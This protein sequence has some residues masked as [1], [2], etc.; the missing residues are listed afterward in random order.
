MEQTSCGYE[1]CPNTIE[2]VP[3]HRHKEYCSAACRQAARRLRKAKEQQQQNASLSY[4]MDKIQSPRLHGI[5][6]QILA[7]EGE[8]ALLNLIVAID[9]ERGC[10]QASDEVQQQLAH[11]EIK[12]SHYREI[13]DLDD[14][15]KIC[16]QFLA[17]GQLVDYRALPRFSI[18]QGVDAWRDY[19]SWTHEATLAEVILY[20]RELADQETAAKER[21][22]LRQVERQLSAA[23][24]EIEAL[25]SKPTGDPHDLEEEQAKY[26][27][28]LA[29]YMQLAK[30]MANLERQ[31]RRVEYIRVLQTRNSMLQELMVLGGRLKFASLTNLNIEEGIDQWLEY[32]RTASDE[33]L[34]A[35]IAHGYYQADSLAMAAIEASDVDRKRVKELEAEVHG[36]HRELDRYASPPRELLECSL[37]RWSTL[38]K[39]PYDGWKPDT[40]DT[41]LRESSE[42]RLLK[43]LEWSEST[44]LI[45]KHRRCRIAIIQQHLDEVKPYCG[46]PALAVVKMDEK[47]HATFA[48]GQRR[49]MDTD[50]IEQFWAQIVGKHG[51]QT[52][53]GNPQVAPIQQYLC[54]HPGESIPFWDGQRKC[55]LILIDDDALA[56]TKKLN[57]KRLYTED[58]IEQA[59]QWVNRDAKS[60]SRLVDLEKMASCK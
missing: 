44:Y 31:V 15:K 48:N 50:D 52:V 25:K 13:V 40:I 30:K 33:D 46:D 5:L 42:R 29:D 43:L 55:E 37:K 3:G 8:V 4:F 21:S 2:I 34:A 23:K 39:L 10:A 22:K 1:N 12:L 27:A 28:L 57:P 58:D 35:A 54:Q 47:G 18:R 51:Q 26:A 6:E 16:Q 49:F 36:L 14:R 45:G 17:A 7:K 19:E 38:V 59:L 60:E 20:C 32:A 9:D 24:A 41:F 56:V 53:G 11:L